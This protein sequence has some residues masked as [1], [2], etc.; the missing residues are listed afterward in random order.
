[1]LIV[2]VGETVGEG[3]VVGE[4]VGVG[5]TLGDDVGDELAVGVAGLV[6]LGFVGLDGQ[7]GVADAP[8]ELRSVDVDG[9]A[10]PA[11]P[12]GEAGWEPGMVDRWPGELPG[13]V[14]WFAGEMVCVTWPSANTPA[15]TMAT[16]P[17]TARAG[18]SQDEPDGSRVSIGRSRAFA[19]ASS[20]FARAA[21]GRSRASQGSAHS[22]TCRAAGRA[23]V[24][25]D[26]GPAIAERAP[27]M[28]GSILIRIGRSEPRKSRSSMKG[29]GR[30]APLSRPRIRS[31]PSAAGSTDSAAAHSARR[32]MSP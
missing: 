16:A 2:L 22:R 11:S 21:S 24:A 30:R 1:V 18:L 29:L 15:T 23:R 12:G 26:F 4:T 6:T 7:L 20:G 5:L 25:R 14:T 27:A 9:L 8:G 17:A 10:C 31:R 28:P 19:P 32:R 13:P 3:L